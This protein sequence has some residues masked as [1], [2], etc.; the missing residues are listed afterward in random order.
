MPRRLS[1][2][3]A[4]A[5]AWA[6]GGA[7]LTVISG[8]LVWLGYN[9]IANVDL[10]FLT[11]GPAPGSLEAG[12]EGGILPAMVGT[13]LV[14]ALGIAIALPVGLGTAL[15]LTEYREPRWLA[16]AADS[17][18]DVIFG[19]PSI[20]F[21]IL[22][23]AIFIDPSLIFLSQEVASSG[24]AS[25]TSF[26][27]AAAMMALIAL[28]P[29]VRSSQAAIAAVPRVRREASFALGKGRLATIRRVVVPGARP[30]IVTGVILGMGRIAGDTAIVWLLL[31]GSVLDPPP[32]GWW[33][34][35]QWLNTLRSEGSTLTTYIFYSSPA[36][37]GNSEGKAFGA[38]FVLLVLIL[39]LNALVGRF[40]G[41][42][43]WTR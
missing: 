21:A 34:P 25:A 15:F 1:D 30:G 40:A 2:R 33:H 3:I 7:L 39:V 9:G 8:V 16:R 10:D 27:C 36:G 5:L 11:T 28:P 18:V 43:A 12:V 22:G 6:T 26:L 24:Q 29:I 37:E 19:V 32:A 41:R 23:L 38:A 35:D 14:I 20:V 17:C 4:V 42:R 13:V 31:G